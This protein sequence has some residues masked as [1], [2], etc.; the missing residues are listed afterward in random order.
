MSKTR[1][2]HDGPRV[3]ADKTKAPVILTDDGPRVNAPMRPRPFILKDDGP[4]VNANET[5]DCV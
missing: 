3:N 5:E 1:D 4:L 2:G